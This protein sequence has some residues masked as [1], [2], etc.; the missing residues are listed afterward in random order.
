MRDASGGQGSG[1]FVA[2]LPEGAE[3][4]ADAMQRAG[5]DALDLLDRVRRALADGGESAPAAEQALGDAGEWGQQAAA[6]L[7]WRIET[8]VAMDRGYQPGGVA[9]GMLPFASRQAH[10]RAVRSA[11]E[12]LD[13]VLADPALRVEAEARAAAVARWAAGLGP[14][15]LDV[16]AAEAPDLLGNL[17]GIPLSTRYAINQERVDA[18][19]ARVT[20]QLSGAADPGSR[21]ALEARRAALTHLA[22][23]GADGQARQLLAFDPAGDGKAV[24][25]FGDLAAAHHAAVVVP[26]IQNTLDNFRHTS[27][28]ASALQDRAQR[29]AAPGQ[30]V[31]TIAWMGYDT[32]GYLDAASTVTARGAAPD[33]A[34]FLD[35]Q[36]LDEGVHTTLVAHSYGTV[37]AGHALAGGMRVDD[38][39]LLGSPGIGVDSADDIRPSDGDVYAIRTVDDPVS[40]AQ[41]HGPDPAGEEFGASVLAANAAG[42]AAVS[43][44]S[45]Y[46]AVRSVSLENLANVTI[47]ADHR[48]LD[49]TEAFDDPVNVRAEGALAR[50][51]ESSLIAL[52]EQLEQVL[53][54]AVVEADDEASHALLEAA[55][56]GAETAIDALTSSIR[57]AGQ[58][59]SDLGD[60]FMEGW[61]EGVDDVAEHLTGDQDPAPGAHPPAAAP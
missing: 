38:A 36:G 46:F 39:V 19:L 20:R 1:A 61:S 57:S 41:F 23:P 21:E 58:E 51:V 28:N 60:A 45:S 44:H 29:I 24:E 22:G 49:N 5:V 42:Y 54:A 30:Q 8:M 25:V 48:L 17:D 11:L 47:D 16:V 59:L 35:G 40:M 53:P 37:V 18:E 14:G 52:D 50:D 12:R 13:R 34:A 56:D 6:D 33:L 2:I 55:N 3:D 10:M 31:A 7:R 27:D 4:L 15:V 9:S 26:G 32:P 43:G